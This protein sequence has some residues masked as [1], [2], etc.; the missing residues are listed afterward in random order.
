MSARQKRRFVHTVVVVFALSVSLGASAWAQGRTDVVTLANGDR[1]TGEIVILDRGRLELK[2]DDAGTIE[3]EWDNV[4]ALK[5]TR[6]FEVATSDGR[7]LLGSL[8]PSADRTVLLVG[9]AGR[10]SLAMMEVTHIVPIGANF[11]TK[12][13]GSLDAGFSYTRSSGV[14]QGTLNS[15]TEFRRPAFVFRLT[16]SATLTERSDEEQDDDRA[17]IEFSYVRYRGRRWFASG[18]SRFENNASLGL[19]LRAQV[20]GAV[21]MRLVN[22]NRAQFALSGGVVVNNEKGVD[23]ESTQNV[24]G[25][26]SLAHSFYSYDRPKTD[27]DVGVQY[28]PSLSS[29]GRQRLQVD[30]AV[31]RDLYKD[32]FVALNLYDTFDS[33]PPNPDAARN[34]V[35]VVV[36]V[37]W[38]Y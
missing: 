21:G 13:D 8:E 36:S 4:T 34:D 12:L 29:L 38:S 20:G 11:W 17:A 16:G 3:I 7:R 30:F 15:D 37:G 33:A 31:R 6:Q 27:L 10:L 28:Y 19:V 24:E 22:T 26:L 18:V 32:F 5:A 25:L 14:A 9:D 1:F 2:T 35:G 23:T